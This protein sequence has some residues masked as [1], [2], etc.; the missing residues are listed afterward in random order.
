MATYSIEEQ[1]TAITTAT[2]TTVFTALGGA[3]DEARIKKGML[4]IRNKGAANN[5]ILV[6]K[7]VSSATQYEMSEFTLAAGD[8]WQNPWDLGI[9][10]TTAIVRVTTSS[11][12]AIDVVLTFMKK[13]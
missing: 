12:S 7:Y 10:G 4:T 13:V 6:D 3:G 9:A 11:T 1:N 8:E 5:I 2:T